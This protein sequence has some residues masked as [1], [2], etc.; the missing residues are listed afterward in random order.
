MIELRTLGALDLRD[1][2]GA[3]LRSLL[4]QPSRTALLV[5]L[6]VA[7]PRGYHRRDSLLALFWPEQD[8]PSARVA[9][10]QALHQLRRAI[11]DGV[12]LSR[13]D[14]EVALDAA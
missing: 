8:A 6:G 2:T 14:E 1:G 13:G 12:L 4:V 3:E 7:A 5:Y 9:L 10:R 11:G